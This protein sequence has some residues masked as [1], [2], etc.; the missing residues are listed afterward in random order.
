MY[1]LY[2]YCDLIIWPNKAIQLAFLKQKRMFII[3]CVISTLIQ[4]KISG[5]TSFP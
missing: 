1:V 5:D 2:P 3:T 4:V